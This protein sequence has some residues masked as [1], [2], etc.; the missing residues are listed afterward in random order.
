MT[1]LDD[2][3]EWAEDCAASIREAYRLLNARVRIIRA[4]RERAKR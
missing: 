4:L 2:P 3:K 1:D